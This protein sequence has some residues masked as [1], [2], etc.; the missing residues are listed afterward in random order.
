[1]ENGATGRYGWALTIVLSLG[2][3]VNAELCDQPEKL[4]ELKRRTL[5]WQGAIGHDPAHGTITFTGVVHARDF[6]NVDQQVSDVIY[7]L[8]AAPNRVVVLSAVRGNRV[9]L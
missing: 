3:T 8:G 4:D 5:P 6:K 9:T 2:D 1:M 7:A